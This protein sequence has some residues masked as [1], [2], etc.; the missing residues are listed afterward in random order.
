MTIRM[1][2]TSFGDRVLKALGKKRGLRL[3]TEAYEKLGPY[4]SAVAQKE[5]FWRALFRSKNTGL[6][7]GYVDLFSFD[8]N[9]HD[10]R[11]T[12]D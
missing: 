12:N 5:S 2:R 11:S 7:D 10:Q 1:P 4:V 8:P 3:P 6:P 9:G